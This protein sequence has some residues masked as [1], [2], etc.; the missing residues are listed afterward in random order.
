MKEVVFIKRNIERWNNFEKLID[1]KNEENPDVLASMF[2]QLTDDLAYSRTFYAQSDTSRY[3]N[4]LA[5]KTHLKIYKNKKEDRG[6]IKKFWKFDFPLLMYKYKKFVGISIS[7]FLIA[8]LIGAYSA[9]NDINFVR[10]ILGDE[11][12]DMTLQN[13]E[14]GD[15]LAVYKSAIQTDMFIGIT[16]NNIGVSF[17][18]FIFGIFLSLGTLSVLVFNGI[19]L[20]SFQYFFYHYGLLKES[21]LTIWIHG[22]LEIF[23]IIVSGAAG[24]ILGSSFLFPKS[25]SRS[26]SFKRGAKDGIQI[27]IGLM[28]IFI[29]AAFLEGFITRYTHAPDFIR[30]GIILSSLAFIIWYFFLYPYKLTIKIKDPKANFWQI[31]INNIYKH[32]ETKR[33]ANKSVNF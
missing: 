3:L 11:Y 1:N 17:R 9:A 30:F 6:L 32:F 7:V 4:H 22:T 28:P 24:M 27:V 29:V 16:F 23:A 2:I 18:A 13:I 21:V 25:Y 26:R 14:K 8:V 20:G 12:V 5:A 31:F 33:N 15:P 10:L 19:M